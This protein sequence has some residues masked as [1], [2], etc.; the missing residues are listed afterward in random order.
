MEIY[1]KMNHYRTALLKDYIAASTMIA[2]AVVEPRTFTFP[3]FT[4]Q[5][6]DN[7]DFLMLL[8]MEPLL[9]HMISFGVKS[10]TD[11]DIVP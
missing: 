2:G 11:N 3:T 4:S 10:V 9:K 5:T 6:I 1:Q 7:F 8:R